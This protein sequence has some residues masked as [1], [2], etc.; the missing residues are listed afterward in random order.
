M[1]NEYK[2]LLQLK[3][4]YEQKILSLNQSNDTLSSSIDIK[5]SKEKE[6]NTYLKDEINRLKKQIDQENEWLDNQKS[7]NLKLKSLDNSNV[8]SNNKKNINDIEKLH[9]NINFINDKI[10]NE[11]EPLLSTLF[12]SSK[13]KLKIKS[14]VVKENREKEDEMEVDDTSQSFKKLDTLLLGF[15]IQYAIDSF[16]NDPLVYFSPKDVQLSLSIYYPKL[17]KRFE[18]IKYFERDFKLLQELHIIEIQ[19][20]N[21]NLYRLVQLFRN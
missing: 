19:P 6:Y 20:N 3:Y 4:E 18:N 7:I 9:D 14:E 1:N 11:L 13:L 15:I 10:E 21:N 16:E 12:E 17:H 5:I 8:S 2:Q